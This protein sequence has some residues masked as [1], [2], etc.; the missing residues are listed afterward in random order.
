MSH[1]LG[2]LPYLF[3]GS[4]QAIKYLLP[5]REQVWV[6]PSLLFWLGCEAA[7]C[8]LILLGYLASSLLRYCL[9]QCGSH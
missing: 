3:S 5:L 8:T 7:F 6:I 9:W 2:K 1:T 4:C